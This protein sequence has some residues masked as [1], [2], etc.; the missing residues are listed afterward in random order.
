[1]VL[2]SIQK[3]F[4]KKLATITPSIS[5]AY[6]GVS[7]TPV[8]NV[9]YQRIQVVPSKPNNP[10]MGDDYYR[11]EGECQIF[12]CYPTNKGKGEVLTRAEL[13]RSYFKRATTLIEDGYSIIIIETPHIAGVST[14]GD[15]LVCP[16][17]IRYETG[18]YPA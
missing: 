16:V 8:A 14:I 17:L 11:E 12:L 3:A 2:V 6:E 1:M 10:T 7:F 5:T 9:P 4:E 13:T 15:R 18:V